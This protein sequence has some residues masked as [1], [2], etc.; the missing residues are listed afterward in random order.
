[1]VIARKESEEHLVEVI[2]LLQQSSPTPQ[3]KLMIEVM[4]KYCRESGIQGNF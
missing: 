1:M 3:T 2:A 4:I